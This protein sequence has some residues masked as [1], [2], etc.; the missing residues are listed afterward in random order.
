MNLHI[1]TS[2]RTIH[3]EKVSGIFPTN[4]KINKIYFRKELCFFFFMTLF[5]LATVTGEKKVSN[6]H[7]KNICVTQAL[8][9]NKSFFT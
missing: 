8:P 1:R 5:L 9:V 3:N 6:L 7:R 2:D 4:L